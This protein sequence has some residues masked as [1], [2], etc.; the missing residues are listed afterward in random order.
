MLILPEE[1]RKFFK[2][3]FGILYPDIADIIPL[4]GETGIHGRGCRYVPSPP[5]RDHA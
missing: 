3:P 4:I 2:V 1:Q 5:A